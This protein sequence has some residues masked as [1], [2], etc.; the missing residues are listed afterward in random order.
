MLALTATAQ[1]ASFTLALNVN[2]YV[3]GVTS[4]NNGTT[5]T[6]DILSDT[7]RFLA[8]NGGARTEFSNGNWRV[9]DGNGV[10]RTAMGINI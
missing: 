6:F 1:A 4:L 2:G 10:L 9:Y 8:P 5:S 3:S 7:V